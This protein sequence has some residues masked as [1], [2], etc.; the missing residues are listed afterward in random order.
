MA[1]PQT[2]VHGTPVVNHWARASKVLKTAL[3]KAH[4]VKQRCLT[5]LPLTK[6]EKWLLTNI[7]K[8][9]YNEIFFENL[10]P[11]SSEHVVS[12]VFILLINCSLTF[13]NMFLDS[14]IDQ[15]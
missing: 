7:S 6:C 12:C 1:V 15:I 10:D 5:H 9:Q 13:A 2:I 11:K 14:D 8:L 4:A 3:P